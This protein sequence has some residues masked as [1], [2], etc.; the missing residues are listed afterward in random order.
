MTN[1]SSEAP[2]G[3]PLHLLR[4]Q[5]ADLAVSPTAHR[6]PFAMPASHSENPRQVCP[7]AG[8][9]GAAAFC[10]TR[11]R[12]ISQRNLLAVL[13][14]L[15]VG[16]LS[17][18]SSASAQSIPA[19]QNYVVQEGDTCVKI[20]KRRFGG[21]AGLKIIHRFNELGT[22]PHSL[23]PGQILRLPTPAQDPDAHLTSTQGPVT[24][25]PRDKREW[26]DGQTGMEL[27]RAWRVNSQDKAS[28][29]IT[30]I[31][32]SRVHM[33]ENTLVIIYGPRSQKARRLT[34]TAHLDKGALH[35]ALAE[36]DGR[37]PLRVETNGAE[38]DFQGGEALVSFDSGGTSR[39][40]NHSGRPARVRARRRGRGKRGQA[41]T[42]QPGMG[43]H[44]KKGEA[45]APPRPLPAAPQFAAGPRVFVAQAAAETKVN[46][47]WQAVPE[48][49]S[50]RVSV[51]ADAERSQLIS[52][53]VVSSDISNF[54]AQG[55]P[56]G[57][58]HITVAAVDETGLEGPPSAVLA[59]HVVALDPNA[60]SAQPVTV[61]SQWGLPPGVACATPNG[62]PQTQ[63]VFSEPGPQALVCQHES[64][65]QAQPVTIQVAPLQT[66]S[67]EPAQL[68]R[69]QS[70]SVIWP[71][72]PD[73]PK[74]F[75]LALRVQGT[76]FEP[77]VRAGN[78]EAERFETELD[79]PR[80]TPEDT[81]TLTLGRVLPD[82]QFVALTQSTQELIDPPEDAATKDATAENTMQPEPSPF[83]PV[84]HA[85][86]F[87]GYALRAD[88]DLGNIL[89]PLQPLKSST[90]VGLRV[91]L[92]LH[93]LL[94]LEAE[95]SYSESAFG[96]TGAKARVA[97]AG[98]H[99]L[100]I[101]APHWKVAPFVTVG[102][103]AAF[104]DTD[105]P[106][107][108]NDSDIDGYAGIGAFV[109]V[110]RTLYLRAEIRGLVHAAPEDG[111]VLSQEFLAGIGWRFSPTW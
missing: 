60:E 72:P 9:A 95:G 88:S 16:V 56:P 87:G 65:G 34:T 67:P 50:Y 101:L 27:F 92:S 83:R 102:A 26:R 5:H 6:G 77:I 48:A 46:V 99:L 47:A 39:V 51:F 52:S 98:I 15:S 17:G 19:L 40:A 11:L 57:V 20:A 75:S 90:L 89:L 80:D 91:G 41:V 36:L 109:D 85:G 73:L 86:L 111:F 24:V 66:P 63:I 69:G 21:R 59:A 45:P 43:T 18:T 54:E 25:R 78:Q 7:R 68:V 100:S 23:K 93:P 97:T 79:V 22:P 42:V 82:G 107:A 49:V 35:L 108:E 38:A 74:D 10:A 29:E 4:T 106:L 104:L 110:W 44:V 30:F 81:L 84:T 58:H 71:L 64:G 76:R 37:A 32:T 53:S 13:L 3:L 33:R 2:R 8:N 31:D 94:G 28:A 70:Q 62:E 61:A 12:R 105:E 96:L 1:Y 14:G 103:R 55:L